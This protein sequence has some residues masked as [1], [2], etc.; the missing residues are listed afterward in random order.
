MKTNKF[1]SVEEA[2]MRSE[3][4]C[5]RAE[6]CS[7]EIREKL[8]RWGVAAGEHD[9]II[10]S[11][12]DRR[13]VDDERFAR[14]Y[15]RDKMEFGGWGRRKIAAALYQ[16]RV[17]RQIISEALEE[18]DQDKYIA[19]LKAI[20]DVKRRSMSEP[21]TYESRTRLF[22]HAA[23]RGFEPELIAGVLRGQL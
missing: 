5:A 19:K 22:R 1:L 2:L 6:H 14:A 10:D 17:D 8:Y 16:K 21:D 20:I 13:F 3:E 12:I 7:G 23:S 18:L 9:R 15:A 4:L 11:L